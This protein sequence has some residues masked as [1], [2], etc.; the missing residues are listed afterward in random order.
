MNAEHRLSEILTE[1]DQLGV[2]YLVMGGHAARYY[3]IQRTT[4]DYDLHI[5]L[6]NWDEL[7]ALLGRSLRLCATGLA[8]GPSWRPQDFRRFLIGRLPDGRE[9]WLE[10]WRRN[11]LLAPFDELYPR[12]EVGQYG[13]RQVAFLS[14]DDLIRSKQTERESD[15][16]DVELLE[17]F[18][19]ARN[20]AAAGPREATLRML[21]SLRGRKGARRAFDEG[22]MSD[23]S[24]VREAFLRS[25]CPVT[26]AILAPSLPQAEPLPPTLGVTGEIIAGPLR[27]VAAGTPR[28]F[29][30][31]EA[32][33]RQF[34]RAAIESDRE[35][36]GKSIQPQDP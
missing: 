23:V 7:A 25:D 14:L 13:G 34:K 11:H 10:F 12:R 33:R 26:R 31:V 22:W 32:V 3:G 8:E 18:L 9:E 29:M 2:T 1:L 24:L 20:L 36:K 27:H 19:D 30:L 15:W 35:D 17:E 6:A 16:R 28:H 5:S 21:A 4:I